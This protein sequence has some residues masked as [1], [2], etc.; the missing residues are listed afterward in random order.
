MYN[1]SLND[2][3]ITFNDLEKKIYKYACDEA[4]R[5]MREVLTHLG[6]RLMDERDTKVYRSKGLRHTCIKTIMGNVE[7]DRRIYEYK[8][9]EGKIARKYLLDEYLQM[10]TI[11]HISST[12]VEKIVDN[13]ANVSYRNTSNNIKELTNQEISHTAVWNVVQ[14][15][16]CKIEEKEDRKILLNKKGQLNGTKE[17][18]VLFQEMDGIWLSIQGKDRPKR[19][20]SKKKELKLG[21]TYEGW[22]KRNGSKDAYVVENKIACASFSNSKKFKELSDATIAENYNTDEIEIRILNGDGAPWI[23]QSVEEE[24]VYYQLDPFHKSQAVLRAVQDKKEAHKLIKM[25]SEGKVEESFE[26]VTNLMVKYT[27][28]ENKFKKLE[29]LYT[30][31]FENKIGLR[32]YHLREEIQMPKAPEGLEYRNLGTMEHNICDILAQR[33]KGRKM[34]WSI[35][36]ANNLAKILAEKASKR[37]YDVINEVCSGIVSEDKLETI[38]E[39]ITLTAADVNKKV[40][41]SKYYTVQQASVPFTG[42]AMTNGRKA[43]QSF[44]QQRNFS[45]LIY[46]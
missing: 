8:T 42:C 33:M 4:S 18:N 13:I 27:E 35:S 23:K 32:P 10:D 1:T 15:L 44:F 2:K 19:R 6:R 16:G 39:M 41:K 12:L 30:Y 25:L 31:L 21:I 38:T 24:G 37:I 45:E 36:G 22:K 40:K 26:Y 17:V 3:D 43:I 5:F 28:D 7:F 34:S 14:K 46:R 11:G 9:D 29:K 20:K